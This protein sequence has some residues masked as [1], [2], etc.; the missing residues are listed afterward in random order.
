M[1]GGRERLIA[2]KHK[3]LRLLA[4]VLALLF[5]LSAFGCNKKAEEKPAT[6]TIEIMMPLI[7]PEP[8]APA[9]A[10]TP[11]LSAKEQFAAIDREYYLTVVTE[12]YY[13]FHSN[14]RDAAASG[15]DPASVPV[16]WGAFSE[17]ELERRTENDSSM[18]GRLRAVDREQLSEREQMSYDVLEQKLDASADAF[19]YPY[20]YEPL[21]A[22][23]GEHSEIPILLGIYELRDRVDVEAYLSLLADTPRYLNDILAYER[24]KAEAGL[25]MTE[26]ALNAVM[27]QLKDIVGARSNFYLIATFNDALSGVPG[28]TDTEKSAYRQRNRQLVEKEFIDAYALLQSGLEALR[29]ECRSEEGLYALGDDGLGYYAAG[30]KTAGSCDMDPNEALMLLENE[31][32][33]MT[34]AGSLLRMENPDVDKGATKRITTG[35]TQSDLDYLREL[36]IGLLGALPEHKLTVAEIPKELEKQTGAVLY[37]K[38]AVD[39]WENNTILI[40]STASDER[41]LT[42]LARESYPGRLYQSL[43][44]RADAD[45]GLSQRVMDLPG[46]EEGWA[47]MAEKLMIETQ[48]LFAR[49]TLLYSHYNDMAFYTVLPAIVSIKVNYMGE[50]V[51]EIEQYLATYGVESLAESYCS[52]AI[53]APFYYLPYALGYCQFAQGYR[54]AENDLGD[55]FDQKAYLAKYLDLGPGQY[56]VLGERMDVWA[57][58]QVSD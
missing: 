55:A 51:D 30:L 54:S 49:D 2:M 20:S 28:L 58:E 42:T 12:N 17:K 35:D 8:S 41:F 29:P 31:L 4:L 21:S 16:T 50:S 7:T 18:L 23:S 56:N 6:A 52:L 13:A 36:S 46:Y 22:L 24:E 44:Q 45:L 14:I 11:A 53:V 34:V 33:N 38:S 3:K 37:V 10:E 48:G 1:D 15:I 32:Y 27:E 25:F 40:N 47:Q 19:A 43:S 9:P 57:D 39:K 26:N 5:A